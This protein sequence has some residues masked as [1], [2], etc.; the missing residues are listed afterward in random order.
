MTLRLTTLLAAILVAGL[1]ATTSALA[2]S[3]PI[4]I[5]T[6]QYAG[7][8]AISRVARDLIQAH[9]DTPV[10]LKTVSVGVAF[11]GT[12]HN[13]RSMFLAAWLPTTHAEYM[14]R[15]KGKVATLGTI[16][17][18]ARLG[19]AVPDYV[20]EDQLNSI[21][22]LRKP[23]IAAKLNN[24]I[25]GISPGAGLMVVSH[26]ALK[27]YGLDNYRISNASGAA[28]TAALKRAI[29]D[30]QWI[31]V[32]AWS[33][34]WMWERFNLR[35]LKDPKLSLGKRERV[36]AIAHPDLVESAPRVTAFI[37][38]MHFSLDQINAMLADANK[39]SYDTAAK[40]FIKNHPDLVK[41]WL[42]DR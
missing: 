37:E 1:S 14:A 4:T 22:D 16:Y 13:K 18:G 32:T 7:D 34:H 24:R 27:D 3:A 19:W 9:Y 12:T 8:K 31:V 39:T 25:Q 21:A 42:S 10:E 40:H 11:V 6:D 20:P 5:Y 35:Y 33:P 15:V 28:M 29:K 41:S 2:A 38:R 17:N 26:D 36:D 23:E 30:K